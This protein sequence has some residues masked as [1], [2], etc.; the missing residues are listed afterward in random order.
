[1]DPITHGITGALLGK[2]YFADRES[3][4]RGRIAVFAVTLGS[5]F[6]D[7]DVFVEFLLHDPLA[8]AKVHRGFTHSFL[9]LPLF[10]AALAW[11][12]RGWARRRN[13]DCPT[14][15]ALWAAYAVGIVSHILLD[16]MTSFGTRMWNPLS[17]E[18]VAWDWLFIVDFLL[19]AIALLPQVAAWIYRK[20][21][22]SSARALRM[23]VLFSLLAVELRQLTRAV[24]FSFAM[25]VIGAAS[26]A[27]AALFFLPAWRGWGCRVRRVNWCRAGVYAMAAYLIA[28][29]AAHQIALAR[30]RAFATA[31][32]IAAERLGALPLP[33]SLLEWSG[34]IRT[35]EGVYH[36][37]FDLRESRAPVFEFV[38]DSAP[39]RYIAEARALPDVKT[40]LWFARFPSIHYEKLGDQNVVAFS[41]LRFFSRR[42]RAPSPFTFEVVFDLDGR[43]I[44]EGWTGALTYPQRRQEL[45]KERSGDPK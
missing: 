18:R 25:W 10:A 21:E 42:S 40:Y 27:L 45:P 39:N 35:S 34:L 16:G 4:P 1:M 33:P 17:S 19:A 8:I 12:T 13:V 15:L 23:W 36:S 32:A 44:E 20:P 26:A 37:R 38:P 22:G 11:L 28:C 41:D 43:L 24:G 14:W 9:G 3:G 30:V 2:A 6:P 7:V 31:N 29:G 5:L